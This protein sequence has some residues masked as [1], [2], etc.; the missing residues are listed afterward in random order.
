MFWR[1]GSGRT[2]EVDLLTGISHKLEEA[3]ATSSK[4]LSE[5]ARMNRPTR[6]WIS[7][8]LGIATLGV[9][10]ASY[11]ATVRVEHG[12]DRLSEDTP[13]GLVDAVLNTRPES[14]IAEIISTSPSYEYLLAEGTLTTEFGLRSYQMYEVPEKSLIFEMYFDSLRQA[15][16]FVVTA[17][18][19]KLHVSYPAGRG[20][21]FAHSVD[22]RPFA[23]ND[24]TLED[25]DSVCPAPERYAYYTN[26]W[27][28]AQ[29]ACPPMGVNNERVDIVAANMFAGEERLGPVVAAAGYDQ[30]VEGSEWSRLAGLTFSSF[31]LV[32]SG[33]FPDAGFSGDYKDLISALELGPSR[34][35]P[36]AKVE[37][38]N[39]L[40]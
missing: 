14:D 20:G 24:T 34:T 13:Q 22:A 39:S 10:I 30:L 12:V 25:L 17:T 26:S 5:L 8:V 2:E 16:I 38:V 19:P 37:R 21:T 9:G 40:G 11:L 33:I 23:T 15:R 4:S 32:D 27:I 29:T 18:D 36:P 6:F 35:T 1:R 31:A 28:Y 7:T 3:N